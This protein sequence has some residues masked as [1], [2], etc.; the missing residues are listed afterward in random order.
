MAECEENIPDPAIDLLVEM[1]NNI[2]PTGYM[3]ESFYEDYRSKVIL[4]SD[5]YG[6]TL[7]DEPEAHLLGR[8]VQDVTTNP[9]GATPAPQT[10]EELSV[11]HHRSFLRQ[12]ANLHGLS[13]DPQED[14]VVQIRALTATNS[15]P[16]E[17][18]PPEISADIGSGTVILGQFDSPLQCEPIRARDFKYSAIR[19]EEGHYHRAVRSNR[20]EYVYQRQKCGCREFSLRTDASWRSYAP[21]SDGLA[22]RRPNNGKVG[23]KWPCCITDTKYVFDTNLTAYQD[24]RRFRRNLKQHLRTYPAKSKKWVRRYHLIKYMRA[25]ASTTTQLGAYFGACVN[26]EIPYNNF[27]FICSEDIAS[28][29]FES[30]IGGNNLIAR[31]CHSRSDRHREHWRMTED[32]VICPDDTTQI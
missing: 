13:V 12:Y 26:R 9:G 14:I 24:R 28:E 32:L 2:D 4:F 25:Y 31:S 22:W 18:P 3:D 15:V 16:Q 1:V 30:R 8:F 20:A 27:L 10:P 6:I 11:F 17:V 5:F 19:K 23:F 21:A 7:C 29:Y